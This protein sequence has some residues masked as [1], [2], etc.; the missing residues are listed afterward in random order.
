MA[1]K[2]FDDFY[3]DYMGIMDSGIFYELRRNIR[4]NIRVSVTTTDSTTSIVNKL[5][6]QLN[7]TPGLSIPALD[8][9]LQQAISANVWRLRNGIGDIISSGDL[10]RSQ[11]IDLTSDGLRISYD[12]PYASL[13]HYGG[14]I[15][16]YG[17]QD[18]RL[19]YIPGRPWVQTVLDGGFNNFELSVVYS[20]IILRILK[21]FSV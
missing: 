8:K 16:P 19:V 21:E 3:N 15:K 14:Y 11:S 18:A 1:N 4:P 10:L 9:I 13:I 17:N 12:V 7:K 20:D 2:T 6:L 5:K